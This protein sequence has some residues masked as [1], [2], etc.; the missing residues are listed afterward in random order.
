MLRR[1]RRPGSL[2]EAS[3]FFLKP[4]D[5]TERERRRSQGGAHLCVR[6]SLEAP[7]HWRLHEIATE[8]ATA[9]AA[10]LPVVTPP[11]VGRKAKR[12]CFCACVPHPPEGKKQLETR[13][14]RRA[15]DS[16]RSYSTPPF[17][18]LLRAQRRVR[19]TLRSLLA[20]SPTPT[21]SVAGLPKYIAGASGGSA[22][23]FHE[24]APLH[25][26]I[27]AQPAPTIRSSPDSAPAVPLFLRSETVSTKMLHAGSL[28]AM[29]TQQ[30]RANAC[31]P[32]PLLRKR[33]PRTQLRCF[34]TWPAI[35][36][37]KWICF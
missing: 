32:Q 6:E 11:H 1:R 36:N 31:S 13:I 23:R 24:S 17:Q 18:S 35:F 15:S 3:P 4:S 8:H 2:T 25:I 19:A 14:S 37:L 28:H 12:F 10:E 26:H 16:A 7:L 29:R 21:A 27:E 30:L 33:E 22:S 5:A 9:R 20:L 34:D